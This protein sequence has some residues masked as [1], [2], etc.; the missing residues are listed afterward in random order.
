MNTWEYGTL[1]C[2][3]ESGFLTGSNHWTWQGNRIEVASLDAA[4]NARGAEG[5]ELV[6]SHAHVETDWSQ[7][8]YAFKRP[9]PTKS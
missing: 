1:I 4:L 8:V 9:A 2:H 7:V 3:Y 6:T 5:W